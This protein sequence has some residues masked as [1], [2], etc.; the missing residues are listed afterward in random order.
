MKY[1][2]TILLV[3]GLAA[4]VDAG[5]AVN[6]RVVLSGDNEEP[7]VETDTTGVA[8]VHVNQ[9]LTEITLQLDVRNADNALGAAGAHFHCGV[10][11]V[12]GPVVA[13]I[14]GMF[15][16]GYDGDFQLRSTLNDSN[17]TNPACG[18]TIADLVESMLEGRVYLNVH[19]TS[20]PGGVIRGQ[21]E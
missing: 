1:L 5:N 9:Q 6:F 2:I 16:P 14:A 3:L 11:G 20:W 21:V 10:A 4:S 8:L 12:N 15:S 13:F 17:V 18:A 7:P 19:S